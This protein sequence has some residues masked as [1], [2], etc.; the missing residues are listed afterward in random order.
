MSKFGSV[1]RTNVPD[2]NNFPC[3]CLQKFSNWFSSTGKGS[4]AALSDLQGN[5]HKNLST[6]ISFKPKFVLSALSFGPH[7]SLSFLSICRLSPCQIP[8]FP[9]LPH[10]LRLCA[11]LLLHQVDQIPYVFL[12]ALITISDA[13]AAADRL[14]REV[15]KQGFQSLE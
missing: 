2:K 11:R 8:S 4:A 13:K 9:H 10:Y 7:R 15:A 3:T 12:I 1:D 14:A 6:L 5:T